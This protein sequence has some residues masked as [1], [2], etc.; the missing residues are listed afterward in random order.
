MIG[1]TISHYRILEELGAGGMGVVYKA[2]DTRL[3][4]EVAIKFLPPQLKS[5]EEAKKRFIHE[6]KAASALNHSNIAVIH[7]IDETPDGQMFIVMAYYE[8]KTL[9][10]KVEEGPLPVDEAI[11]IVSQIASGLAKAHEKDILHRDIKPANILLTEDGEAKLADFGLAKLRGQTRLTKTGTTV[12]TVSY[13]SPEQ[14]RGDEI[15]HQ[16]D[17]FSLG[18]VLYELLT[19]EVPFKGDHEAAV[20]Y[21]I[22]HTD[23]KPLSE[24]RDDL[25]DGLQQVLDTALAK[26]T[27]A[28]YQSMED[29][30]TG[31]RQKTD[32]RVD[33]PRGIRP[34][35]MFAALAALAIIIVLVLLNIIA[36]RPAKHVLATHKQVTF[37][38][39]AF[40]PA[41]SPDGEYIA[42]FYKPP[43]DNGKVLVRALAGGE[44]LEVMNGVRRVVSIQWS[45]DGSELLIVGGVAGSWDAY[46]VQRDGKGWR[47][48][49]LHAAHACW[50]HDGAG[51]AWTWFDQ[52][53][54]WYTS[55]AFG[56]TN[57]VALGGEFVWLWDFDW[58]PAGERLLFLTVDK[59]ERRTIWTIN[60]DGTHQ[61]K[62]L[63]DSLVLASV[64][65]APDGAAI[66]YL[67]PHGQTTDLM[68][69]QGTS[70]DGATPQLLQTGLQA[71]RDFT[72]SGDGRRLLYTRRTDNSNLWMVTRNGEGQGQS[73]QKKQLT[74][75]TMFATH[76]EISPDN[77]RIAFSV[78]TEH[79]NIFVMPIDGGRRQQLTSFDSDNASPCWS[80]DGRAIA[81]G[82]TEGG[83]PRVWV[84]DS[85]GG[86]ARPFAS[87]R[88]ARSL[89]IAWA[90]GS[91]ILYQR[92]GNRNF[93]SLN[94]WTEYERALV[95]TDTLGWI[96][97]PRSSPDGKS[98][99][100]FW[101][102]TGGVGVWLISAEDSS[103]TFLYDV[104]SHGSGMTYPIQWSEDGK[105][106]YAWDIGQRAQNVLM[107]PASGGEPETLVTVPFDG[108][109]GVSMTQDAKRIVCA[110]EETQ[111]DV[112]VMENFDPE[113]E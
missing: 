12:G 105:W 50:L 65:W 109:G 98:L 37:S 18:V 10:D 100:V 55:A 21:G 48:L 41:I 11:G 38:G 73:L 47:N 75:G 58:S 62:V 56:D 34:R 8:G 43:Q 54:I 17:V 84:M 71:G 39:M 77:S 110:V 2:T 78:G 33:R 113:V 3:D 4:R 32:K 59:D 104:D 31:L 45:P 112:W 36:K 7:E 106:I 81:F 60:T 53:H 26:D 16:S 90:P 92:P 94:P 88:L 1:Q 79:S 15:D 22:M 82:S 13:M 27:E 57:T 85:N 66:Y 9:K 24:C 72:V 28:R 46:V 99:A 87:S 74:T 86:S 68:K 42:Y 70:A 25:P 19:G 97:G 111:S 89:K 30:L 20:L 69:V 29:L 14:A 102:Q 95:A 23:P 101:N 93:H 80:P 103:H 91:E 107:I 108:I 67:R 35:T 52:K 6:A 40:A 76:P 83:R 51:V 61:Q 49:S 44:P 5:N 96:F 64:R 63:V